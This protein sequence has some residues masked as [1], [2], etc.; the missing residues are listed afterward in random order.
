MNPLRIQHTP[1]LPKTKPT[2]FLHRAR[3]S[4]HGGRNMNINLNLFSPTN[5]SSRASTP[6]VI[7]NPVREVLITKKQV[8]EKKQLEKIN[9]KQKFF[10]IKIPFD[11]SPAQQEVPVDKEDVPKPT[12][13][14]LKAFHP[15][16]Q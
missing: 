14:R 1:H 9:I 8:A 7:L 15:P 3:D 10:D 16:L 2:S 11:D 4:K 5:N 13:G 6:L 12:S